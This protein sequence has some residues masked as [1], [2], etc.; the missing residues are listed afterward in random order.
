MK[1][2]LELIIR[3]NQEI[4]DDRRREIERK[5]RVGKKLQVSFNFFNI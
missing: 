2:D 5:R 3:K 4:E 1:E